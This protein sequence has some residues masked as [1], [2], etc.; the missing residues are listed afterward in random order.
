MRHF[1]G[2][3][4]AVAFVLPSGAHALSL[5]KGFRAGKRIAHGEGATNYPSGVAVDPGTGDVFVMDLLHNKV[6]RFSA[7]GVY[8]N[9]W[10]SR[11]GLG[12]AVDPTTHNVWVAMWTKHEVHLYSPT[13]EL[14]KSLGTG[15]KGSG[16]GE[17]D[18]P[19]DVSVD[20]TTGELYVLDTFNERV[21]VF[22]RDGDFVRAFEGPFIQPFGIA[23]HPE[24]KW[25]VIANTANRELIKMSLQGEI[26][27]RW[28]RPGSQPGEFRWPRNVSVDREGHIYLADTDNERAQE[29]DENGNF[30]RFIQ[31]PNDRKHGSFHPR[32]ID[33]NPSDG[34]VYACA[35]Y[36]SRIDRFD[37]DG[38]YMQSFGHHEKDGPYF[39]AVKDLAVSPIS[40]DIFVSDW[41]DHRIKVFDSA[42]EYKYDLDG[43]VEPQT[44]HEGNVLSA[45]WRA[46]PVNG[47]WASKEHQAFPGALEFDADGLLWWNRGSMHYDDDPRP[48]ADWIV[49]RMTTKGSLK[50]GFGHDDFPRNARMRGLTVDKNTEH[51][52]IANSYMNTVMKFT[53]DGELVWQTGTKGSGEGQFNFP[54]GISVD[55]RNHDLLV[56]DARNN[57]IVRL[58]SD[59]VWKASFG[60]KGTAPG[61]FRFSDFSQLAVD[62]AGLI[63][64]A[65]SMNHRVQAVGPDGA[66]QL[67]HGEHGFGGWGKYSGVSGLHVDGD[68]LYIV[69][70]GGHEFEVWKILR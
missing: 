31:G 63:W 16:D 1:L 38:A 23:V 56:V 41:M 21:Q 37:A 55:P 30:V 13:G 62:A 19:H 66:P 9:E 27:D 34:T 33:V 12:L 61:Q 10:F 65:D 45:E 17:F 8:K 11:Q 20:P 29:L 46:D 15:K 42:G 47:M 44:D 39:N 53:F 57:R 49:R 68:R 5:E 18:R 28:K 52:Y 35:A 54:V 50:K 40:G 59:G 6:Q 7:D 67:Q 69:D 26:L 43:W 36:A 70:N 58:G 3:T 25:L 51:V 64:I 22:T 14:L 2:L 60:E 24:G 32:A 48:Q 4:L